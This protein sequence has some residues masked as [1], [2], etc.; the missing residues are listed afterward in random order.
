MD[1]RTLYLGSCPRNEKPDESSDDSMRLECHRFIYKLRDTFKKPQGVRVQ[2][3]IRKDKTDKNS[4]GY[5][6]YV[7]LS[8]NSFHGRS[9]E[10]AHF[11]QTNLPY[12]W[13]R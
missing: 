5:Y 6:Y 3:V 10:F 11:V 2:Y 7:G 9:E 8:Y 13:D 1:M 4:L 12:W